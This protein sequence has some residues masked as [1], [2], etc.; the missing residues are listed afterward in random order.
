[1]AEPRVGSHLA[2]VTIAVRDL[3]AQ[4]S[5]YAGKLGF[6]D[7]GGKGALRL[8]IP[9]AT[10]DEIE[11]DTRSPSNTRIALS[12]PNMERAEKE[13]RRRGLDVQ[14]EREGVVVVDPDGAFVVFV[15][16]R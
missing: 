5:F 3:A 12:A 2:R 10:A 8:R 7:V 16:G 4:R 11:L 15:R 14:K 6:E 13:L 1:M 9:G